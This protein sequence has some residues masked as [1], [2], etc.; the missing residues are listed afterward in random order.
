MTETSSRPRSSIIP[1]RVSRES[2]EEITEES[3]ER[4]YSVFFMTLLFCLRLQKYNI[5]VPK[6]GTFKK[7]IQKK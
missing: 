6:Y 3:A 7:N 2:S 5:D 1:M 4:L